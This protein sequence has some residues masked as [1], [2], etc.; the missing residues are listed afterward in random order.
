MAFD[1]ELAERIRAVMVDEPD[2]SEK[3]MFGGLGFMLDGNMAVAAS[4]DGGLMVRI[5]PD[6]A[7]ELVRRPGAE[8]MEM[9]GRKMNGWLHIDGAALE[10][11]D[12][13]LD[14]VTIG[15]DFATTL[16]PK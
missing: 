5:D 8:R 2:T 1:E 4:S 10:S 12:V 13:L 14:W 11:D 3:K 15:L 7:D 16:P 9:K 6:D